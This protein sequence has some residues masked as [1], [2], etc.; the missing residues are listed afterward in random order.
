MALIGLPLFAL[1]WRS[2]GK[3]FFTYVLSEN[4]LS[5][6]KLSLLTSSISVGL[7][8]LTGTPLAYL[9]AH[10]KFP[11]RTLVDMLVDLPVVL[12]P[13]LPGLPY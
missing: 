10:W 1:V 2:I 6:L 11:G 5:A 3:D 8:L 9:L 12:P 4:A 7:A 13:P